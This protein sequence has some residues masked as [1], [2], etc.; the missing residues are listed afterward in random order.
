MPYTLS[1]KCPIPISQLCVTSHFMV[2]KVF[3]WWT[4]ICQ[5][6][7]VLP[8][9][10]HN[11]ALVLISLP[12]TFPIFTSSHS[13]PLS[14]TYHFKLSLM[15]FSMFHSSLFSP[16]SSPRTHTA[17]EMLVNVLSL[18]SEDDNDDLVVKNA[19]IVLAGCG[20]WVWECVGCRVVNIGSVELGW[21]SVGRFRDGSVRGSVGGAEWLWR[22]RCGVLV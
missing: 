1:H 10:T 8:H 16:L 6:V 22:S 3:T 21:K 17:T 4:W 2:C 19:E 11:S 14:L 13:Y 5:P 12:L 20:E 9:S 18:N 7:L 15:L